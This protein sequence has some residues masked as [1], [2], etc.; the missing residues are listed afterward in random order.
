MLSFTEYNTDHDNTL[1]EEAMNLLYEKLVLFRG[2][3]KFGQIVFLAGGAGCFDGNTLVK[4]ESG[5]KAIKDIQINEMVYTKNEEN[6]EVELKRV[7]DLIEYSVE[8]QSEDILELTFEN[9]ETVVCTE[10]HLFFTRDEWIAAKDLLNV[11]KSVVDSRVVYD[12]SIEDNH[13]YFITKSDILVHNSGKGF[14]GEK[15]MESEKF[16]V[17]DVDEWKKSLLKIAELKGKYPEISG[18][19][20]REPEDVTTL[21]MFVKK[22]GIKDNTLDLLLTD[23]KKDRLPNIMFDITGKEPGDF[24]EVIPRLLEAG[25]DSNNIHVVWILANW[26]VAFKANLSRSRVVRRDIFLDTHRGA[27]S[28]MTRL[29]AQK[30]MPKGA[31]GAFHV[32]MNNRDNTINFVPG[33]TYKGRTIPIRSVVTK[34]DPKTGKTKEEPIV[35]IK[36]FYYI[37]PKREGQAWFPEEK[38]KDELF[39]QIAANIPG[40]EE[41]IAKTLADMSDSG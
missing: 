6:D 10:N 11:K 28:S 8:D 36:G 22:L 26:K 27:G 23:L 37:T 4:T 41:S 15:F 40:G 20:L 24:E 1:F 3:A 2:G 29:L 25:Y 14:A 32:I 12:L 35:N 13:N 31:N 30:K 5:Y 7:K 19:N 9:G 38:W 16:K 34:V 21:H 18:L 33:E 17:R 39:Q